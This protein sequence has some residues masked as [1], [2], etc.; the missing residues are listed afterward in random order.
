MI[1]QIPAGNRDEWLRLRGADVTASVAGALL[2]C[3]PFV[4]PFALWA[5]KAGRMAEDPE[6]TGPMRRGRLLEPVA[7]QVLKEDHPRLSLKHNTG[8]RAVYLR[9]TEARIGATV[10]VFAKDRKRG[11]GIIQIK[12]VEGRT[13]KET[14][15]TEDG[16]IEPP[17]WIV[18]QAIVEAKLSGASWAAV[19]P[20][21]VGFGVE[22][23]L[24]EIPIH[25]G[26]YERIKAETARFWAMI[27]AG[28]EPAP[29]FAADGEALAS[30]Y[31]EDN[32]REI[33][34]SSD[35]TIA[36]DLERRAELKASISAAAGEVDQIDNKII[37]R[38]GEFER[39]FVP[40]WRVARPVVTRRDRLFGTA[41]MHRQ[42]RISREKK[43]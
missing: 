8:K 28:E 24:V 11:L 29:D 10:D 12:S 21:T 36:A 9:D 42:L 39:A 1:E 25:D 18:I 26:V 27:E 5:L 16:A 37:A 17:L 38:I 35:E 34:L 30:I 22:V 15:L 7:V 13:F 14:W 31:R 33:D 32:G 23:P 19:A 3:H 6:E 2:G 40:G 43:G 41:T 4:T 20:L